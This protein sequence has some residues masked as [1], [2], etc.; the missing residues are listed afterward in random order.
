MTEKETIKNSKF[1]SLILRH[2][3]ERVGLNLGLTILAGEMHRAG[4]VFRCWAN[5]VWLGASL[6]QFTTPRP[7]FS[8]PNVMCRI[9]PAR[10]IFFNGWPG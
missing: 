10:R 4:R 3:P 7:R 1:L 6:P 5:G 2:E 8:N 9:S